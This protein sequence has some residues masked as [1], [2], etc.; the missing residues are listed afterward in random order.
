M[1]SRTQADILARFQAADDFLGFAR[2]V[3]A[4]SMDGE[5]L[6]SVAPNLADEQLRAAPATPPEM[7]SSAASGYLDF[8]VGKILDHRGIS[9]SRSVAKL[10]EYAWL[11]GRDDVVQAMDDAGYSQY[12]A[13]QVRAFAEGMGWA[14]LDLTDNASDREELERM[15]L[16]RF[17]EDDC[18]SG[19]GQ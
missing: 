19:C 14:F 6:R 4:E 7:L 18:V 9:A 11:L 13:P 15:S 3:L 8:A 12:G 10:R 5:T 1:S 2:D 16:G 17:C